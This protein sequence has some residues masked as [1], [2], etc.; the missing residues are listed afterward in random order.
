MSGGSAGSGGAAGGAG[1][2]YVSARGY[3]FAEARFN[4]SSAY[5]GAR[6]ATEALSRSDAMASAR[7]A[8]LE[9]DSS[10]SSAFASSSDASTRIVPGAALGWSGS[11]AGQVGAAYYTSPA[12]GSTA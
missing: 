2:L 5:A 8:F 11:V 1:C 12:T 10:P 9:E 4:A 3:A 6:G 7:V